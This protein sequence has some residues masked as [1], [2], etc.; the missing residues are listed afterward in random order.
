MSDQ[1]PYH[2]AAHYYPI[3]DNQYDQGPL[4]LLHGW[5]CD[6]HTWQP[7]LAQLQEFSSVIAIDLPGFGASPVPESF[8]LAQVIDSLAEQIPPSS[9]LVGWSLGGMLAV[10]LA[11]RLPKK[12]RRVITL[13]ANL[14]FVT[15]VDYPAAMPAATFQQFSEN[16]M[17]DPQATLKRFMGLVAQGDIKE[18]DLR[19][20]LRAVHGEVR[21]NHHWHKALAL[22][23]VMDNQKDFARLTQSGLHL[24]GEMDALVPVAAA[25][26]LAA[27][28]PRQLIQVL[29][30]TA[31]A[32]HW[33]QPESVVQRI[34][35][36]VATAPALDKRKVAHSFSRA[37]T[38]YDSAASLQR[39]VGEQLL[40][41]LLLQQPPQDPAPEWI[42]DVGCGTGFF[43]QKLA[44]C[45][46]QSLLLGLDI[47]E[48]MLQLARQRTAKFPAYWLTGDGESLPLRDHSMDIIFSSLVIQWCE[49]LPQLFTELWRALKPG[50]QLL[51]STLGPNTLHELKQ[52]WGAV[53]GYV[54][55]NR[56]QSADD[57]Q[58]AAAA[59]GFT[60]ASWQVQDCVMDFVAVEDL[61]RELKALGAHNINRGQGKG[62][63]GRRKLARVKAAYEKF[64]SG[65]KLPAT[66][67]VF[68]GILQK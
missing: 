52:A 7:V 62:L 8:S 38:T 18:R 27:Q 54:H 23:G 42:L 13:A 25:T 56:F 44:D 5:G 19:K 51:F 31:H 2:I 63:T 57:I 43:T 33:S 39:R 10:A 16:F 53:D 67:E 58:A 17:A 34:K 41:Q 29:P 24:F 22:L 21:P 65:D 35:A 3:A 1:A 48:G 15:A 32:M 30:G 40:R 11:A 61:M 14:R 4:V 6:S 66:Y 20:A 36:F 12:I 64:R 68:Y 45:F 59:A 37:A 60:L 28:H 50:G 46:P 9:T 55:V 26:V 49:N 47:A